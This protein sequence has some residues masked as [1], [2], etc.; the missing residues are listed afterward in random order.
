MEIQ[1]AKLP[2]PR[3]KHI[4]KKKVAFSNSRRNFEKSICCTI[5]EFESNEKR[6]LEK[7]ILNV[8]KMF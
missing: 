2:K 6:L 5:F 7:L 1:C 3:F 8:A 4:D